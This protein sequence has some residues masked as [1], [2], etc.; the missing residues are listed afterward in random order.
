MPPEKKGSKK[1]EILLGVTGGIAAYRACDI[2]NLLR[3]AGYNVI[4]VMTKEAA[5]FVTPLALQTLARNRVITDMF[6]PVEGWD[7]LHTSFAD[8]ADLVLVAPATANIIG[9][10]AN[11]ICDDILTCIILAT[12][13]PVLLAPAMNEKMYYNKA[14]QDNIATLKGRGYNL[15]GP[16][17]GNLAC[18]SSGMGHIADTADIIDKVRKLL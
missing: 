8:R 6:E 3:K 11:G 12:E 2:I 18:G 9:K 13:A 7:P 17:K 4:P 1:K 14:V 10:L 5:H 15:V 16:I